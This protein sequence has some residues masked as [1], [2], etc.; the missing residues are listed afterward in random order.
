MILDLTWMGMVRRRNSSVDL[1]VMP[2]EE[3]LRDM[4]V[5]AYADTLFASA[6]SLKEIQVSIVEFQGLK[7][8]TRKADRRRRESPAGTNETNGTNTLVR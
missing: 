5:D 3:Y 1:P 6:A 2:F 4:D 7:D 8:C